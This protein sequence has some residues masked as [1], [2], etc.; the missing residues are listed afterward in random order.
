M[1]SKQLKRFFSFLWLVNILLTTTGWSVQAVYCYCLETTYFTL[2]KQVS[3]SLCCA[4]VLEKKSC[5]ASRELS[6]T[7]CESAP[8]PVVLPSKTESQNLSSCFREA[9][10]LETTEIAFDLESDFS[11]VEESLPL[12]QSLSP[13]TLPVLVSSFSA[14]HE[15][16]VVASPLNK[17]PPFPPPPISGRM[18]CILAQIYRC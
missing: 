8:Y 14:L 5:C 17:A 12:V 13:Y 15:Q 10:C 16:Q 11:T 6:N 4:P 9:G 3:H 18:R 7:S 2:E 1:V